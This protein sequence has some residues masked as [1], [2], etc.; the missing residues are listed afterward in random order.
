MKSLQ[1]GLVHE[2]SLDELQ[3]RL[4]ALPDG[5]NALYQDMWNRH[6]EDNQ[7]YREDAAR[8]LNLILDN[9]KFHMLLAWAG[10]RATAIF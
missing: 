1:R 4:D 6:N 10:V 7:V 5:L 9:K 3:R 2:D 8:Y